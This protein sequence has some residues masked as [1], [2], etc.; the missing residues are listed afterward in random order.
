[1]AQNNVNKLRV[2]PATIDD[3]VAIHARVL[4]YSFDLPGENGKPNILARLNPNRTVL[5]RDMEEL[6]AVLPYMRVLRNGTP[7]S[8]GNG[9]L[10]YFG[11][12][13]DVESL[14]EHP[15][16]QALAM[17]QNSYLPGVEL[18]TWIVDEGYR[19][20]EVNPEIFRVSPAQY[21]IDRIVEELQSQKVDGQNI[22]SLF[23]LAAR[24]EVFERLGF[25]R[26][27]IPKNMR[28]RKGEPLYDE[29]TITPLDLKTECDECKKYGPCRE[30]P[31]LINVPEYRPA[32]ISH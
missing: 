2:E 25:E 30:V 19:S 6:T 32:Q 20:K 27:S 28:G 21:F 14:S 10:R 17:Q 13:K 26:V 15:R 5:Y 22:K 11:K 9:W 7:E 8:V 1:M 3:L 29:K 12:P 4:E 31:L 18:C 23:V 16:V 24:P